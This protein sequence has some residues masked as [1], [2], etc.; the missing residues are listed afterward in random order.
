MSNGDMSGTLWFPRETVRDR[1][2][3]QPGR[4]ARGP[5]DGCNARDETDF[6][7]LRF[8]AGHVEDEGRRA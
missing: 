7:T 2:S 6:G 5:L 3:V 8:T 4:S 1:E